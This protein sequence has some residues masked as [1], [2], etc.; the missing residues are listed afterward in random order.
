MFQRYIRLK[1]SLLDHKNFSVIHCKVKTT[2]RSLSYISGTWNKLN[3]NNNK[4]LQINCLQ[5]K[6]LVPAMRNRAEHAEQSPIY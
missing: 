3:N 1:K 2:R 6:N 4:A 5:A